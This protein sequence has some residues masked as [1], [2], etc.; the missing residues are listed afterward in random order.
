MS[1]WFY[2]IEF[3]VAFLIVFLFYTLI[4]FNKK[5]E[6]KKGKLP[7]ELN[8][9]VKV[10]NPDMKKITYK[11]LKTSVSLVTSLDVAIILLLTEVT[12][13]IILKALIGFISCI[14]LIFL[15]YRLLGTYYR[16]K[17]VL[18]NEQIQKN[19]K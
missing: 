7:T 14:I 12:S 17:G 13:N 11:K 10:A 19:R 2:I 4:V 15:S 9:F 1:Y 8:L 5:K 3:S 6:L 16:K 18:K